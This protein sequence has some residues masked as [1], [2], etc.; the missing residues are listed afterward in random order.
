MEP[1]KTFLSSTKKLPFVTGGECFIDPK[2]G[3]NSETTR[4][5]VGTQKGIYVMQFLWLK[6]REH[7]VLECC[8]LSIPGKVY[9]SQ[10]YDCINKV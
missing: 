1:Q 8:P 10:K 9:L 5:W 2:L 4:P 3:Q 7:K 6:P